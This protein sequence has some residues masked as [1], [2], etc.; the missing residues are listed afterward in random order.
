[1]SVSPDYSISFPTVPATQ[2][3]GLELA[4]GTRAEVADRL[5]AR[6]RA[7]TRTVVAFVNA[8]CINVA[9]SVPAYRE[10]LE[11]ADMLLPDG[12]RMRIAARLAGKPMGDNLNGTDLFP[13]ICARAAE[14]GTPIFLFGGRRGVAVAAGKAMQAR[15]PGLKIAGTADGYFA[16]SDEAGLVARINASGAA[17][18][19]VGLG[20]P[21]QDLLI[22][23]LAPSLAPPVVLGVGGLFDYYSG[24]IPRAPLV[25]RR[26]GLQWAWRL[27]Q[28]PRRLAEG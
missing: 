7:G 25:L 12:V 23:R 26:T 20:V 9:R 1:M 17:M 18:L 4:N 2:L 13:D 11:R 5:V 6:A 21:G 28:E 14:A 16:P 8:H 24:R 15:Y 3:F 22:A 27:A 19:F 10:A